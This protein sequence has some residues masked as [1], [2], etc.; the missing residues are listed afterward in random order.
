MS[1]SPRAQPCPAEC[2]RPARVPQSFFLYVKNQL[3]VPR[4]VNVE[5]L[6]NDVPFAVGKVP[7][8]LP[9]G[10]TVKVPLTE[11]APP[12]DGLPDLKGPLQVR[13]SDAETNRVLQI[14][15]IQAGIASPREYVENRD[16]EYVPSAPAGGTS[17]ASRSAPSPPSMVLPSPCNSSCPRS[18]IRL[19]RGRRRH[20]AGRATDQ[21]R[22]PPKTLFAEDIKLADAVGDEE[23][24]LFDV[25]RVSRARSSSRRRSP[26]AAT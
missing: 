25:D 4:K 2:L 16:V 1:G 24:R 22:R 12:K 10:D 21:G 8:T 19:A 26:A 20:H 9:A 14:R 23:V 13:V 3:T 5:L 18:R 15:T 11:A 6:V 7:M 17:S